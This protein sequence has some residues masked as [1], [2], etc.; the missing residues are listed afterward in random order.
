MKTVYLEV[1]VSD[2]ADEQELYNTLHSS[3]VKHQWSVVDVV[4]PTIIKNEIDK[5]S[6]EN[7]VLRFRVAE[8]L[9]SQGKVWFLE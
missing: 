6:E 1:K 3:L 5:L 2:N 4:I 9:K 8:L 7:K